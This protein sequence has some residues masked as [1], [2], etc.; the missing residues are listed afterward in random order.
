MATSK[1]TTINPQITPVSQAAEL[2]GWLNML[3]AK[4]SVH[5]IL[6]NQFADSEPHQWPHSGLID[7]T[8]AAKPLM[9]VFADVRKRHLA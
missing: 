5:G 6:W 1:A 3:T 2:Q 8:G 4:Q 7:A 9:G